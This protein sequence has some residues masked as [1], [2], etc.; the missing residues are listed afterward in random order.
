MDLYI[1]ESEKNIKDADKMYY[2]FLK[3]VK[4]FDNIP[5]IGVQTADT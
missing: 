4:Q 5:L 2:H 3:Q 1:E